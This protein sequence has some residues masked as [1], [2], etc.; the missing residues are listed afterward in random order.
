MSGSAIA[1]IT[2]VAS[3]AALGGTAGCGSD[4]GAAPTPPTM[5]VTVTTTATAGTPSV[6]G[7]TGTAAAHSET[8]LS[9]GRHAVRITAV[10]TAHGRI[11][12]DVVQFFTGT[13]ASSAAKADSAPEVP[14]PNDYWI[15]NT[16]PRLRT[17]P[18]AAGAP[19]TVNALAALESGSAVKDVPKTLAQL[20]GFGHPEWALF[21]VTLTGGQVTKISEQF[22]P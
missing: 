6:P 15:R 10:D 4:G 21:W 17:L 14:P 13:A 5:T 3:L 11:T 2:L 18:V 12:V 22:L 19:I 7:A 8:D 20:A 1:R 9:D 16:N